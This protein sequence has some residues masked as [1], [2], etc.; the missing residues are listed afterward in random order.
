MACD[1]GRERESVRLCCVSAPEWRGHCGMA[2]MTVSVGHII[3]VGVYCVCGVRE[4]LYEKACDLF[5]PDER[6]AVERCKLLSG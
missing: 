2:G 4:I 6:K 1:N 3:R 5:R